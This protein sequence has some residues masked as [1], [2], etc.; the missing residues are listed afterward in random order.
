MTDKEGKEKYIAAPS[1]GEIKPGNYYHCQV[2]ERLE[3]LER[4]E[5]KPEQLAPVHVFF[6]G[7]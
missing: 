6:Q 1:T 3:R 7:N 4:L 5:Y 2:H